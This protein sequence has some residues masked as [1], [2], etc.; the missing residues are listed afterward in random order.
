MNGSPS[1]SAADAPSFLGPVPPDR[2]EMTFGDH[3]RAALERFS[4]G[5]LEAE[6][7]S[8]FAMFVRA[9]NEIVAVKESGGE[10]EDGAEG[11]EAAGDPDATSEY[12]SGF[13]SPRQEGP[14]D[15]YGSQ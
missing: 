4:A 5:P 12:G 2:V 15:A 13:G 11:A 10:G 9:V 14:I 6:E 8:Q 7:I 1:S 3:L